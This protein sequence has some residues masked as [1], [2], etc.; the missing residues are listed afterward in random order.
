MPTIKCGSGMKLQLWVKD[1]G[2]FD[3]FAVILNGIQFDD[4]GDQA[5]RRYDIPTPA[6]RTEIAV[7]FGGNDGGVSAVVDIAD[8]NGLPNRKVLANLGQDDGLRHDYVLEV[9]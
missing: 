4:V 2:A 3:G 1:S 6:G 9:G 7:Q 8:K 5:V